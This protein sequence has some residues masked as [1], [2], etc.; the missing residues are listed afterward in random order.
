MKE[1]VTSRT[2]LLAASVVVLTATWRTDHPEKLTVHHMVREFSVLS[3]GTRSTPN[4]TANVRHVR[5]N[6]CAVCAMWKKSKVRS[7]G[8]DSDSNI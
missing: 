1:T 4:I 3:A 7:D 5:L 6:E 8:G 2:N